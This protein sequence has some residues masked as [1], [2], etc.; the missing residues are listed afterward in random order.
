MTGK[1]DHDLMLAGIDLIKHVKPEKIEDGAQ[2]ILSWI[3][4]AVGDMANEYHSFVDD[5]WS[6][7]IRKAE[8]EGV[9]DIKGWLADEYYNDVDTLQDLCGDRIHDK[10]NEILGKYEKPQNDMVFIILCME[11]RQVA[12]PALIRALDKLVKPHMENIKKWKKTLQKP[13]S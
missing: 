2:D 11:M 4:D 6:G 12:H 7:K 9:I 1:I 10:C 3:Q 8:R 5:K 13:T